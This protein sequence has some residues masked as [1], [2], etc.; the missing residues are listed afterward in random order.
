MSRI[1]CESKVFDWKGFG[2]NSVLGS[3]NKPR[4]EPGSGPANPLLK[5]L[6]IGIHRSWNIS[7]TFGVKGKG[8]RT[9]WMRLVPP[10]AGDP[11]RGRDPFHHCLEH[12]PENCPNAPPP[13][14]PQTWSAYR[15]HGASLS[16]SGRLRRMRLWTGKAAARK[17]CWMRSTSS[18]MPDAWKPSSRSC[19]TKPGVLAMQMAPHR[20]LSPRFREDLGTLALCPLS[21][22]GIEAN[23]VFKK[24]V[25]YLTKK[26]RFPP[27]L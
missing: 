26:I 11:R 8:P 20:C 3:S 24:P 1:K 10:A 12:G 14:C 19:D 21:S 2:K 16:H 15:M 13:S 17:S 27:V 9:E 25:T 5:E 22:L 23:R 4:E 6:T 18:P 7:L